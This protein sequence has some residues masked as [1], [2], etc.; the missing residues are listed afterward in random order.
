MRILVLSPHTDD[1]EIG[2]GGT[3]ARM[4]EADV[5]IVVAVF[6]TAEESLPEGVPKDA[7]VREFHES[8]DIL[9][10]P[11]DNRLVHGYK[12]RRMHEVRQKVLETL[13][14][15]QDKLK[16]DIVFTPSGHDVHQDHQVLHMESLRAFRDSSIYGYELPRNHLE[17]HNQGFCILEER[18]VVKKLDMLSCYKSQFELNRSYFEADFVMSLARV[19]GVQVGSYLAESFEVYRSIL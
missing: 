14:G 1:A 10:V 5:D 3:M 18:H 17:Y 4:K 7:L 12:V 11:E 15:L 2:C 16:P 13:I 9:G 6:S 8:M 19:R